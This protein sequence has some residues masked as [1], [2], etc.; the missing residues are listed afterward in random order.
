MRAVKVFIHAP[1]RAQYS[2]LVNNT[3]EVSSPQTATERNLVLEFGM[4]FDS[5]PY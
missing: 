3:Y 4:L 2:R 5:I 1:K